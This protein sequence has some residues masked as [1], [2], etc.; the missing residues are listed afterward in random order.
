MPPPWLWQ[1][2]VLPI[3]IPVGTYVVFLALLAVPSIQRFAL[4]A[5]RVSTLLFTNLDEPERWGFAKNQATPFLL[6][7][8]DG[9]VLHGWHVLPLR[10]YASNEKVLLERPRGCSDDFATTA[11]FRILKNDP[12]ARVVISFH[13][14]AGHV[15]Q[16]WR[17]AH[18]HAVVDSSSSTHL[19]TVDYR[20][21]GKSTGN[22]TET[23]MMVDGGALVDY[24][25]ETIGIPPDRVVIFGH[26][27]GTAVASAVAERYAS[28][29]V[30][31]AG[32]VLVASFSSLPDMLSGYRI[33]GAI[34][35]M[36]PLAVLCPPLNRYFLK[37]FVVDKWDSAGR[38]ANLVRSVKARAATGAKLRLSLLHAH[39]D[40]NIPC[41]EADKM[42]AA[43][44]G[45]LVG[46]EVDGQRLLEMKDERTV[47]K[48]K[49]AFA[50]RWVEGGIDIREEILSHGGHN[51]VLVYAPS[52]LALL[53]AF[54]ET[55]RPYEGLHTE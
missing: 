8:P 42:F 17:P 49:K 5:N 11:A 26:S 54:D 29:G 1:A 16:G 7:T 21:F 9:E 24:V 15:C 31:F 44:A 23:G 28:R 41:V 10:A 3:I 50:A 35:V 53:E 27:L 37:R 38:I 47:W 30:D 2:I 55:S 33:G 51:E 6:K 36:R 43:A 22:P 12:K 18:Y 48:G 25:L 32:V 4:Y 14:N 34:G 52:T 46:P 13:G 20:G 19:I 45:A 40:W 39:D